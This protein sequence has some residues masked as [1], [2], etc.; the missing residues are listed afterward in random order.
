MTSSEKVGDDSSSR[1]AGSKEHKSGSSK[2]N[3]STTKSSKSSTNSGSSQMDKTLSEIRTQLEMLS[4]GMLHLTPIVTELKTAYDYAME[5]QREE[6]SA[7]NATLCDGTDNDNNYSDG[8]IP[9][10]DLPPAKRQKTCDDAI[11][12]GGHVDNPDLVEVSQDGGAHGPSIVMSEEQDLSSM[13]NKK[14]SFGP[15]INSNLA[16]SVQD[17]LEHGMDPVV[18]KAKCEAIL[19]PKNCTRLDVVRAN[20]GI[21]N[22][23]GKEIK[24]N[25]V[26][27]QKVQRPIIKGVTI[28]VQMKDMLMN[29][30]QSE[31]DRN[32][33]STLLNDAIALVTDGSHELDLRRRSLLK[34]Q[35]KPEYRSLAS[36]SS[37]V[38]ELLFGEEL[39]KSVD[40]AKKSNKIVATV[41]VGRKRFHDNSQ[42]FHSHPRF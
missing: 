11:Q 6:V 9:E 28:M 20:D 27:W 34:D 19:P 16:Q 3:S 31:I 21:F 5:D 4:K 23:L 2:K 41:A 24:T 40:E 10:F 36:E 18:K 30:K 22:N 13:S 32:K 33:V 12:N 29:G 38:T 8:E 39:E 14:Q 42:L 15:E 37:P 17:L 1:K 25:D 26:L 35:L 7:T